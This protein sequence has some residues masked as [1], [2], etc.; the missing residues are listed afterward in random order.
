M[1]SE[2]AVELPYFKGVVDSGA[3]VKDTE[4]FTRFA[5][6]MPGEGEIQEVVE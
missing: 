5:A 1:I 4:Y 6:A 2:R 3:T